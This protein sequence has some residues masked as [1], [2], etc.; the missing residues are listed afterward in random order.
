M[1][2]PYLVLDGVFENNL[3][4][5]DLFHLRLLHNQRTQMGN[6]EVRR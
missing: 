3:L 6:S 2:Y 5:F 4:R 1:T